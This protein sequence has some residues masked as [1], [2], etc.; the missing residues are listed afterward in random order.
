MRCPRFLVASAAAVFFPSPTIH[1]STRRS[2]PRPPN[3]AREVLD[4][5]LTRLGGCDGFERIRRARFDQL[6]QWLTI[7][8][9]DQPHADAPLYNWTSD[10]RDYTLNARRLTRR[11]SAGFTSG[12]NWPGAVQVTK[13]C[14]EIQWLLNSNAVTPLSVVYIDEQHE[15]FATA[16]ERILLDLWRASD[17]RLGAD[18][19]I[20]GQ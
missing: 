13:D 20:A 10:L 4:S 2:A 1:I 18:T 15:E 7:R 6:V 9:D 16:P 3:D 12:G 11:V 19:A 8:F 14:V 5:T 17:L